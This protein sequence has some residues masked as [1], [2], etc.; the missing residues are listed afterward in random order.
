[1]DEPSVCWE[2]LRSRILSQ[3][4]SKAGAFA[5]WSSELDY[6]AVHPDNKGKGIATALVASGVRQADKMG[7]PIFVM[8]FKA[9]R[10]VYARLGFK[11][12]ECI[13]QD[14]SQFGG[15]GEYGAYFMVYEQPKVNV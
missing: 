7:L 2:R 13:I 11:E 5:D 15:K 3:W 8:A 9:G 6:L 10:G 12:V 4:D 1:M 14:D